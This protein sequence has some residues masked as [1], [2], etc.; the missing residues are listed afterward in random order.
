MYREVLTFVDQCITACK[1]H[2]NFTDESIS[3]LVHNVRNEVVT[4]H[5]SQQVLKMLYLYM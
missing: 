1:E 2:M 3:L 5:R 4:I